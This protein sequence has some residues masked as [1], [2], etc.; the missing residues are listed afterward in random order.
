MI[1]VTSQETEIDQAQDR[2][3]KGEIND[4]STTQHNTTLQ[5][6]LFCVSVGST[7]VRTPLTKAVLVLMDLISR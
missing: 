7:Y 4:R 5:L 3:E 1:F 6:H 2:K